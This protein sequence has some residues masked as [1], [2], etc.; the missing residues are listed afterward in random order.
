[1]EIIV[2]R[3]NTLKELRG[4]P[5]EYGTEIDIRA[6]GS[7]L[8][9]NHDPLQS[10]ERFVDYL[11][12]YKHG[13]MTINIK[14][15]GIENEV[16]RLVRQRPYINSYFLLDVEFP[17]LYQA[18]RNMERSIAVR[19][20]EDESIETVTNYLDKVDWVWIDTNTKLPLE[21]NNISILNHFKKCLVCPERWNRPEDIVEYRKTM[22]SFEFELDAVMTSLKYTSKW[23]ELL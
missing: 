23:L 6:F 12:E 4:I 10:G 13:T 1:M 18:S 2:H 17:Y 11:D 19:F 5:Q 3:I 7:N 15:A 9:L 21:E 8:I 22:I 16:L 20:S 14:E